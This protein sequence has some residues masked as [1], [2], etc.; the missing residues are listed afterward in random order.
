[1]QNIWMA[2]W[3]DKDQEPNGKSA[4]LTKFFLKAKY[5]DKIYHSNATDSSEANSFDFGS[6]GK[7][8]ISPPPVPS[9]AQQLNSFS[10]FSNTNIQKDSSFANFSSTNFETKKNLNPLQMDIFGDYKN[11]HLDAPESPDGPEIMQFQSATHIPLG[12]GTSTKNN[13]D[14]LNFSGTSSFNTSSNTGNVTTTIGTLKFKG[15]QSFSATNQ[16]KDNSLLTLGSSNTSFANFDQPV[17]NNIQPSVGSKSGSFAN[18]PQPVRNATMPNFSQGLVSTP[19]SA[20]FASFP[21]APKTSNTNTSMNLLPSVV[22]PVN[23]VLEPN[24]LQPLTISTS[25]PA[26]DDPYAALRGVESAT[27]S[28][29]FGDFGKATESKPSAIEQQSSVFPTTSEP[30]FKSTSGSLL[31]D[32]MPT[33]LQSSVF[34]SASQPVVKGTSN[35]LLDDD[36]HFSGSSSSQFGILNQSTLPNTM[37]TQSASSALSSKQPQSAKVS[38]PSP[39]SSSLLDIDLDTIITTSTSNIQSSNFTAPMAN[40]VNGNGAIPLSASSISSNLQ[41]PYKESPPANLTSD[42]L[43]FP[44]STSSSISPLPLHQD[45][46]IFPNSNFATFGNE[47]SNNSFKANFTNLKEESNIINSSKPEK[48]V[49]ADDFGDFSSGQPSSH[50]PTPTTQPT[51]QSTVPTSAS[52]DTN[53]FPTLNT[54]KAAYST[55][56]FTSVW[57]SQPKVADDSQSGW[58]PSDELDLPTKTVDTTNILEWEI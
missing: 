51:T 25:Q 56:D 58:N 30:A 42:N 38:D 4:D 32:T 28:S 43:T 48:S 23:A 17:S 15:S 26:S 7:S 20:N 6:F 39:I 49:V 31:E 13:L 11:V 8:L 35:S 19:S 22:S 24:V 16:S 55:S 50:S 33:E 18:F 41:P 45:S 2:K 54:M 10:S 36:F 5:Q 1:M 47:P 52:N 57:N 3:N 9:N 53:S 12:N 44:T 14:Q 29:I 40:P 21:P 46:T 37:N 27:T 34:P